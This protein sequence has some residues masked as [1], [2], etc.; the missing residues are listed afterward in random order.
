MKLKQTLILGIITVFL[1]LLYSFNPLAHPV[2]STSLK[3]APP[4]WELHQ[5]DAPIPTPLVSVL[6]QQPIK[7][8]TVVYGYTEDEKPLIGY[9]AYPE[10][11]KEANPAILVIHEWWG[12]NDNIKAVTRRLA[13]E[14]YTALAVDLY[15][16]SLANEPERAR[17]LITLA[18][19][20]IPEL[21]HNITKAFNYLK[22]QRKAPKIASIGWCFGG[23]WSLNTALLFPDQL[24]AAIIYYGGGITT[25]PEQLKT[26]EMPILGIFGAL[27]TNPPVETVKEFEST[28]NQLGK[29]AT[30]HIY[31]GADH[32]FS[33]PSG[34]RYNA[35]AAQDAWEKT[36]AFLS[37][38]LAH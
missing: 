15:R 2:N 13:G 3:K 29:T 33:N 22:D 1:L 36:V 26:L 16:G 37:K 23:T 21:N 31:E 8:K 5:N 20:S 9:L 19:N 27:D 28:L 10:G 12:L 25:D 24:D 34:T 17:E 32:A 38:Y 35:E 30:I 11:K 14:G 6:P 4:M 7:D 18:N